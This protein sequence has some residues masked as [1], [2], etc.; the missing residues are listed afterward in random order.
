MAIEPGII[1]CITI[2]PK[3]SMNVCTKFHSNP[4]NQVCKTFHSKPQMC[5]SWWHQREGQRISKVIEYIIWE[6]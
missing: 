4:S 6:P 2:H 1:K 5:T 3:R